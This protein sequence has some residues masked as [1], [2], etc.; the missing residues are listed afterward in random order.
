MTE[1]LLGVKGIQPLRANLLV[2]ANVDEGARMMK[3]PDRKNV[4]LRI[5]G[6]TEPTIRYSGLGSIGGSPI[7]LLGQ[8][9]KNPVL[10]LLPRLDVRK[11]AS[12]D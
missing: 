12:G 7:L 6:Q 8:G 1:L 10:A 11:G 9:I 2:K 4:F 5:A 3:L